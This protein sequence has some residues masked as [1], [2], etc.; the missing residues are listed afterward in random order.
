MSPYS[1][2]YE[3]AFGGAGS[4]GVT[5]RLLGHADAIQGDMQLECQLASHGVD[6]GGVPDEH[7]PRVARLA[8]GAADWQLLLQIDS[9]PL[10][11]MTWGDVGRLYWWLRAEDLRARRWEAAWLVL[12]SY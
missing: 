10:A 1:E 7:D 11:S 6:C 4:G 9:E 8:A 3:R 5:H 12:Q 2:A